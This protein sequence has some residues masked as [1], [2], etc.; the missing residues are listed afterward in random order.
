[1]NDFVQLEMMPAAA[2]IL[3]FR[4]SSELRD[5][6]YSL[7]KISFRVNMLPGYFKTA[8]SIRK[9]LFFT[10]GVNRKMTSSNALENFT[11]F[12]KKNCKK[13]RLI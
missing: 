8:S 11:F 2:S 1:M 13:I 7:V 9:R 3:K 10:V 4:V 12:R 5:Y 6:Q